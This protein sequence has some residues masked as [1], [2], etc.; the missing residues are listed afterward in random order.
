MRITPLWV[1]RNAEEIIACSALVLM[2]VIGI[3]AVGM[4]YLANAPLAWADEINRYLFIWMSYLGAVVATKHKAHIRLEVIDLLLPGRAGT[5][6]R[7]FMHLIMLIALVYIVVNGLEVVRSSWGFPTA[8]LQ[9]STG[10][11]YL[12]VPVS[13]TLMAGYLTRDLIGLVAQLRGP[14][15]TAAKGDGDA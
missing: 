11:I 14:D 3:V 10:F 8:L 15:L 13:A 7:L 9:I 5:V 2:T 12:S 6:L 1:L 4:R